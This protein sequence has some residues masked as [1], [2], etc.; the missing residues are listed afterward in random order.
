MVSKQTSLE[1]EGMIQRLGGDQ[2]HDFAASTQTRCH[3][4]QD[5]GRWSDHPEAQ[6]TIQRHGGTKANIL[7]G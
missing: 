5:L 4:R 3:L 2:G 7:R 6:G 1:A